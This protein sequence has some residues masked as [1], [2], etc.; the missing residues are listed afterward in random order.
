VHIANPGQAL[1]AAMRHLATD[2]QD[3]SAWVRLAPSLSGRLGHAGQPELGELIEH[4]SM[5]ERTD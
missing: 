3:Q 1:F 2:E 4:L 5:P